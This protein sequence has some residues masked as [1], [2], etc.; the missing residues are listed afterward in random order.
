MMF[1]SLQKPV[2]GLFLFP[3]ISISCTQ[4]LDFEQFEPSTDDAVSVDE[5]G[6]TID[7]S[8]RTDASISNV[9][10]GLSD[11]LVV[12]DIPAISDSSLIDSRIVDH[13]IPPDQA[14]PD[15]S[16]P[17]TPETVLFSSTVAHYRYTFAQINTDQTGY[18]LV[19][20]LGADLEIKGF[21]L[22]GIYG[23][24]AIDQTV[25]HEIRL[26]TEEPVIRLPGKLGMLLN[27]FDAS[28]NSYLLVVIRPN[29]TID[30]L[31]HTASGGT[32]ASNIAIS[33]DGKIAAVYQ[34]EPSP[35]T[36]K[37]ILVKL[38]QTTW[39]TSSSP[40]LDVSASNWW[41]DVDDRSLF[42]TEKFLYFIVR[43]DIGEDNDNPYRL[44]Y[45]PLDGSE[46]AKKV[47]IPPI[48]GSNES[49]AIP[50]WAFV[51]NVDYHHLAFVAQTSDPLKS[52]QRV[53]L[54]SDD[55]PR[56]PKEVTTSLGSYAL[57]YRDFMWAFSP[58]L[59]ISP[60]AK[61]GAYIRGKTGFAI[62]TDGS[63]NEVDLRTASEPAANNP[64][65]NFGSFNW[66]SDDELI[67]MAGHED[68]GDI[69]Y[70]KM[71]DLTATNLTRSGS[72]LTPPWPLGAYMID[73]AW[74]SPNQ[75]YFYFVL[76]KNQIRSIFCLDLNTLNTTEI[77][78]GLTV[79]N[80]NRVDEAA[81]MEGSPYVWLVARDLANPNIFMEDIYVFDQNACTVATK[82]SDR[83]TGNHAERITGA[84]SLSPDG[85]MLA[86][87]GDNGE[88]W[89]LPSLGGTNLPLVSSSYYTNPTFAW[90]SDSRGIVFG[91]GQTAT[92]EIIS[93]INFP[94]TIRQ[95]LYTTIAETRVFSVGR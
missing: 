48:S 12:N 7:S 47:V 85:T 31:D 5:S 95:N 8:H 57:P 19:P 41:G 2:I 29:G 58:R 22:N 67:Y 72:S 91:I 46:L 17:L 86:Y 44:W 51:T 49:L 11:I 77:T 80:R 87:V 34:R 93:L 81:S 20:G 89:A 92:Q 10:I 79:L 69:F 36:A 83:G 45:A 18:Q 90:R 26:G 52:Y 27:L 76:W 4:L 74:M 82:I 68:T 65:D 28:D 62:R 39:S 50:G 13:Y 40:V 55:G 88:F 64:M 94:P 25:P 32:Y 43:E 6:I 42:F 24:M 30:L 35:S 61:T 54:L 1:N 56:V 3:L 33:H 73:G 59:A 71:G 78:N 14:S 53:F 21:G 37:V 70:Y 38:D 16:P 15:Q 60:N 84:I 75:K 66:L 63:S 23:P 9:D